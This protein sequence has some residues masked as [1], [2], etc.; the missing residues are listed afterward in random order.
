MSSGGLANMK[1]IMITMEGTPNIR[2]QRNEV[3][4]L[5]YELSHE[6]IS[7]LDL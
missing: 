5:K 7:L 2:D 1:Y 3:R 4:H 6:K